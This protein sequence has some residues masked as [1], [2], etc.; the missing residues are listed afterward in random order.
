MMPKFVVAAKTSEIG[1]N[2]VKVVEVEGKPVAL[3]RVQGKFYA[4]SHTCAH[5]G[6]PLGEGYLSD[7]IVTC[8]WHSWQY[9]IRTGKSTTVEGAKVPVYQVKVEKD[10]I[11]VAV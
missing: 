1:E 7:H 5:A 10:T 4:V 2:Q 9:D 3:F 11:L 8:P 6:G